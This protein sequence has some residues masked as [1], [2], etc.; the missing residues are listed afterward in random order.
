[1]K[2]NHRAVSA[3]SDPQPDPSQPI[4]LGMDE[5]ADR[6][7]AFPRLDEEQRTRLRASGELRT[8]G[9]GEVL[10]SEGDAG[11]DFFVVESG[12]IAIV[13]GYGDEN[14]VVAIHGP[15][16]FLGELN[17]LTG[18]PTYLTAVVRDAGEVIQMPAARLRELVSEDE[19]LSNMILR[20]FLARRSILI[21][22]GAGVRVVGSRYSPDTRRLREFLARN[23][24]PYHWMDLELD[25]EADALLQALGVAPADTPVVMGGHG[26]LRRPTNAE[27]G[28]MLGLGAAGAPPAMCDVVIVGEGPRASPPRCTAPRRG[29]T[30]RR[31][32]RWRSA[33]RPAR[34]R[35]SRT[36][37]DSRPG[38]REASW[39]SAP[40]YRRA[41][42]ALASS[43]P[44][45]RS[46]SSP[47]TAITRSSSPEARS[48]TAGR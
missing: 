34:R 7:G 15:H 3:S 27:L 12:A 9:A 45:R 17:L 31:S 6:H 33:D 16:R 36:T 29:S 8:V 11:Y 24:M 23:R 38:S 39:P 44:P 42:S 35:E 18:S 21:D 2:E 1:M 13:E 30:P 22:L 20:A 40:P 28:A 10:F 48:F 43:S 41:G 46:L 32:T 5:P 47:S 25:D 4:G 14:R 26:V 19:E 37:W